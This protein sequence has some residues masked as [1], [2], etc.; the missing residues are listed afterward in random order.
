MIEVSPAARRPRR[1]SEVQRTKRLAAKQVQF[2]K[3]LAELEEAKAEANAI[4][5]ERL[6]VA[7]DRLRTRLEKPLRISTVADVRLLRDILT[8]P[9]SLANLKESMARGLGDV[10]EDSWETVDVR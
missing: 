9:S 6:D 8:A 5:V 7:W 10:G 2:E 4:A 3:A 1:P